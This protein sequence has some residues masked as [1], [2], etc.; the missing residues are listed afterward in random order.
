L[1]RRVSA[2][3]ESV[4]PTAGRRRAVQPVSTLPVA[5]FIDA[6]I[7]AKQQRSGVVPT[8]IAGDEEFLRRVTLDLTGEIPDAAEVTRFAADPSPKKRAQKIDDLL[9]SE[10]FNDRWAL[11]FGDLVQNVRTASN[12]SLFYPGRNA[13]AAWIRNGFRDRAGYDRMVRD[14]ITATGNGAA[15]GAVHFISRQ[16]GNGPLQDWY[17]NLASQS[18]ERFLGVP[19]LCISCHDGRGHLE[20]VNTYL[21]GRTRREFWRT[22]AFFSRIAQ[23]ALTFADPLDPDHL[24][25]TYSMGD[26]TTGR[27]DLNTIEG[28][29]SP[30][31]VPAGEPAFVTPA[32]ILTAEEPRD[33]ETYRAAFAR[34]LTA[35]RQ[36]ARAAVNSFWKEMFGIGLVEPVNA[37]DLAKLDTQ[38]SH[39]ELLEALTDDF[40]AH[41]YDVRAL[42]RT[43]AL[44]NTYQLS[45][46]YAPGGWNETWVPLYVRHYPR[47]LQAEMVFDAVVKATGVGSLIDV[48]GAPS[49]ARAVQLPDPLEPP[50]RTPIG[51]FLNAFGRGNRDEIA[52]SNDPSILQMLAIMND[53]VVTS[54]VKQT[55][56]SSTL[57]H[58]LATTTDP[59][60]VIDQ[61]YLATLSRKP[62][63]AERQIALDDFRDGSPGDRAEDL[64]Y[65]LINTLEFL[66][67]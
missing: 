4:V 36:F 55:I 50:A 64:Q 66:F 49:V 38:P 54:R 46:R 22:A 48:L 19:L 63:A 8:S 51:E 47:R 43:M 13:Y 31:A 53:T 67:N 10:A 44:S 62:T 2:T 59:A 15:N 26:N 1:F 60:A 33:E 7:G 35:N 57:A 29:K 27:Y 52:R 6:F 18:G 24:I 3:A 12:T 40:I 56:P 65:A 9:A 20:Q 14:L 5:N 37:F 41:G 34:M 23:R 45:S 11:W 32:F 42:L 25:A 61:I 39:P 16:Q 21:K 30:R 58:I 17:D 28:K